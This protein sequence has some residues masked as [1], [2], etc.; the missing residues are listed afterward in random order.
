MEW[1]FG[2]S[3]GLLTVLHGFISLE[4]KH[5]SEENEFSVLLNDVIFIE[6]LLRLRLMLQILGQSEMREWASIP[7][8]GYNY[9]FCSVNNLTLRMFYRVT[10]YQSIQI[11]SIY[12]QIVGNSIA[13]L[14]YS[15]APSGKIH[16]NH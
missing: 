6:F 4:Q 9:A 15:T 10:I 7:Y 12:K 14:S 2:S 3:K 5:F 1:G 8:S 16:Y 13:G 11:L